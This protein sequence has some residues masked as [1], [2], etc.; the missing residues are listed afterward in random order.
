MV[1]I[2]KCILNEIYIRDISQK[3]RYEKRM[4][5]ESG[6]FTGGMEL[7]GYMRENDRYYVNEDEADIVRL[8]FEKYCSGISCTEIAQYLNE[9]GIN[10]PEGRK[11]NIYSRWNRHSVM[12]IIREESYCGCKI[13]GKRCKGEKKVKISDVFPNIIEKNVYEKAKIIREK[14][15]SRKKN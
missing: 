4:K 9:K 7:F 10:T 13:F 3:V 2:L 12:R 15:K 14:R 8:I 6:K 1:H 11:K 5:I